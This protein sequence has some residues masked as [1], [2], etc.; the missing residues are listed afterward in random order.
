MYIHVCYNLKIIVTLLFV[1]RFVGSPN[2]LRRCIYE[3]Q[4]KHGDDV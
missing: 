3:E 4:Y 2:A 1:V